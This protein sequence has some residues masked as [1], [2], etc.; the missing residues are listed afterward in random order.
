VFHHHC[1]G[2]VETPDET[3]EFLA[4]T[5]ADLIGLCLD[6]GHWHYA[7]GDAVACIQAFGSRVRYLHLKDC[8]PT[9]A[10]RCRAEGKDYMEAV[11]LGVFCPLGQGEVDFPGVVREMEKLGYDGWAIVEQDIL[12][13]D[14]S[15]PKKFSQANRDYLKSIGL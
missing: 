15:A 1:A 9:V 10:A 5:D 7:G 4:R 12:T 14:L 2:Y 8:S 13:D 6:T 11:A 3:R